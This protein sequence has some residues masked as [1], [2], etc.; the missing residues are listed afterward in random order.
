[1]MILD[2]IYYA[3]VFVF[4]VSGVIAA[5]RK[6][7]DWVGATALALATSLGGGTFRDLI[8]QKPV[9]WFADPF[10]IWVA[11]AASFFAI[12][13]LR[14]FKPPDKSLRLFDAIGLAFFTVLGIEITSAYHDSVIIIVILSLF[15][16]VLGGV[17]RDM[18]SNEIPYLFRSTE[19][20]YAV[21]ALLG[22]VIYLL[23]TYLQFNTTSVNLI[24]ISSIIIIRMASIHFNLSLPSMKIKGED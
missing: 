2:Y 14:F 7:L 4:A 16:G 10:N 8:L 23:L 24:S 20:L 9:F 5:A 3:G 15:T 18:L 17:I 6:N 11:F 1:M 19:T 12:V 22:I 21:S 13:F